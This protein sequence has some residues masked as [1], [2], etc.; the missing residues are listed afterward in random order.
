M[1]DSSVPDDG[2]DIGADSGCSNAVAREAAPSSASGDHTD[3]AQRMARKP[4]NL[5]EATSVMGRGL[6]SKNDGESDGRLEDINRP[7]GN[8]RKI[9]KT[10]DDLDNERKTRT[11]DDRDG[12]QTTWRL[13]G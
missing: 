7:Q 3:I 8:Q 1:W 10:S 13:T 9:E 12:T 2:N 4:V 11:A 6:N 5:K